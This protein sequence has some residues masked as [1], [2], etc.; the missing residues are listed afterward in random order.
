MF[1][2]K[3]VSRLRLEQSKALE[4]RIELESRLERIKIGTEFE[5]RRR[6]KRAAYD[7]EARTLCTR[8]SSSSIL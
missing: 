3:E 6:I 7:N 4:T 8:Q 5:R 2:K 1:Y